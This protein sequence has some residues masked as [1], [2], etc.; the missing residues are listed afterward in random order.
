VSNIDPFRI[1]QIYHSILLH[2][3]TDYDYQ[4]YH[5]QTSYKEATFERRKDK[6][7][8]H[9]MQRIFDDAYDVKAI[10]YYFAWMFFRTDKWV[11][12]RDINNTTL[13]SFELEW[14][15][16]G[17]GRQTCFNLDVRNIQAAGGFDPQTVFNLCFQGDVHFATLLILDKLKGV[18]KIMDEKLAGQLLWD[19]KYKKLK[20]FNPFYLAHEPIHEVD[21]RQH[22]PESL[23]CHE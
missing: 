9:K 8:Y 1:F 10:E 19:D 14:R 20:K 22:I 21:F 5:G 7:A 18:L 16:Y 6:Y 17:V 2:Y 3:T 23:I 15:N 11:T 4:L 12:T 13:L